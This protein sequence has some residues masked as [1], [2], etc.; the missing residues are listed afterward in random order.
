MSPR[1]RFR[2]SLDNS[3]GDNVELLINSLTTGSVN[4]AIYRCD[5]APGVCVTG[6]GILKS[7]LFSSGAA[8]GLGATLFY[9]PW[10]FILR[11]IRRNPCSCDSQAGEQVLAIVGMQW[12]R[13]AARM[14]DRRCEPRDSKS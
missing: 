4:S 7:G 3:R 9:D 10:F 2:M 12:T 14:V 11:V 1:G 13:L 5:Q 6:P 8:R